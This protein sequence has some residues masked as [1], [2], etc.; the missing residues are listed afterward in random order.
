VTPQ[1]SDDKKISLKNLITAPVTGDSEVS[2]P[3]PGTAP[4]PPAREFTPDELKEAWNTFAD[5]I[6]DE[7]PRISVTLA[8]VT[9]ELHEDQSVVLKLDNS[10]LKETFD[11]NFRARL[12]N[13]L[14]ISLQNSSVRLS[15][16]VEA[17]ERGEILYSP[18]QKFN[19]MASKNPALKELKKNFNLDYE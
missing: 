10:A 17:T 11:H 13:H 6:K 14:R 12:E 1:T 5:D 15:T 18:D 7:S 3:P 2:E 4:A 16:T 19:H 9:P 8:A